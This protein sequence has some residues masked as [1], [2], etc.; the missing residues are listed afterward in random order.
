MA[1]QGNLRDFSATE[2]LQLLGSQKK[3]GRLVLISGGRRIVIYVHDGQIVSARPPGLENDD[4]LLDFLRRIHRVTHDQA[5]GLA[6]IH[7]QSGRDLED[8]L[9]EGKYLDAED[10]GMCIERQILESLSV[11][12]SWN[13]G[14]YEFDPDHR[15]E[16][17]PA[18]R[19]SMDGV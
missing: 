4:P 5:L 7:Q 10:L 2:I 18:V 1:L 9:V 15:W 13:E 11:G 12:M 19:L 14:T 17:P 6:T 8:L 3:I 16:R